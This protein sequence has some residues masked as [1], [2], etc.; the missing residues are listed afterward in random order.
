VQLEIMEQVQ[1]VLE[2]LAVVVAQ[3][4]VLVVQVMQDVIVP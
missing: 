1:P 4:L 3:T 2:V